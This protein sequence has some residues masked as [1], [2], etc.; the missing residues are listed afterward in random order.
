MYFLE[1]KVY[2]SKFLRLEKDGRGRVCLLVKRKV[3]VA[4]KV[5]IEEIEV[6]GGE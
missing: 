3:V 4:E 5:K 2:V 6:L 1:W